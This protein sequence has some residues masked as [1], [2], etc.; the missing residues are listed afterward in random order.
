MYT[1]Y[2]FM[3]KHNHL[4]IGMA[5]DS[6]SRKTR[7]FQRANI[8]R[9]PAY[10]IRRLKSSC[11]KAKIEHYSPIKIKCSRYGVILNMTL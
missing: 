11:I 6:D 2:E 3:Q 8:Q 4:K 9:H 10:L 5:L 7:I 1:S